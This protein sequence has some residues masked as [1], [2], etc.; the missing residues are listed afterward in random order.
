MR[1]GEPRGGRGRGRAN[2][3]WRGDAAGS[4]CRAPG[5]GGRRGRRPPPPPPPCRRRGCRRGGWCTGR[6]GEQGTP[7]GAAGRE[8]RRQ[9]PPTSARRASAVSPGICLPSAPRGGQHQWRHGGGAAAGACDG[10]QGKNGWAC[11]LARWAPEGNIR[12]TAGPR[13]A[14]QPVDAEPAGKE[15]HARADSATPPETWGVRR[16]K[17]QEPLPRRSAA[18]RRG[19]QRALPWERNAAARRRILWLDALRDLSGGAM[20]VSVPASFS[21]TPLGAKQW[22]ATTGGRAL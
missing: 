16:V 22:G 18:R 10:G 3:S 7:G 12:R 13:K 15:A 21:P 8:G 19:A 5:A 17:E 20:V 2:W 14:A 4:T 6:V 1:G 9:E 11:R